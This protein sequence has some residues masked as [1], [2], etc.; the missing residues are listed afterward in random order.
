[1]INWIYP[2]TPS[3]SH[4]WRFRLGFPGINNGNVIL[5]WWSRPGNSACFGVPGFWGVGSVPICPSW[6]RIFQQGTPS[7]DCILA[8]I[9]LISI[10][11]IL[12]STTWT[13]RFTV[14]QSRPGFYRGFGRGYM[15][16]CIYLHPKKGEPTQL[17][18]WGAIGIFV[19]GQNKDTNVI[20]I[21]KWHLLYV[22]I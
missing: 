11:C 18:S 14:G 20:N 5:S 15:G 16:Y 17:P 22:L 12:K 4:K 9:N 1:M 3:N 21:D 10:T 13:G 6:P 2:P 8:L 7:K 19:V